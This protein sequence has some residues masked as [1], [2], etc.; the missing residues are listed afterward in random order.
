MNIISQW[1]FLT[2]GTEL[3]VRYLHSWDFEYMEQW[4][5]SKNIVLAEQFVGTSLLAT[6]IAFVSEKSTVLP[7]CE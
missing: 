5:K 6:F 3:K 7:F 2:V 4:K 1:E